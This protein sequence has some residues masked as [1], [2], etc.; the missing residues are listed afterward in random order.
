MTWNPRYLYWNQVFIHQNVQFIEPVLVTREDPGN[1]STSLSSPASTPSSAA[2]IVGGAT[3][4]APS[5]SLDGVAER[6]ADSSVDNMGAVCG[7]RGVVWSHWTNI[8]L[9]TTDNL[10]SAL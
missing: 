8:A 10:H 2:S 7:V 6:V 3:S 9:T 1:D 4:T 5:A